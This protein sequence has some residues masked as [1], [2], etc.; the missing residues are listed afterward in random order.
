MG[1]VRGPARENPDC[2]NWLGDFAEDVLFDAFGAV[3]KM[4]K[5]FVGYD[6]ICR[7]G[8]K[9]DA[10]S[11]CYSEKYDRWKFDIRGNDI[12]DYIICIGF[13]NRRSLEPVRV[14][15]IPNAEFRCKT[16]ITIHSKSGYNKYMIDINNIRNVCKSK[17][18]SI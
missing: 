17:K 13:D 6:F 16:G 1:D 18:E 4:P 11:C 3:Q 10:K 15:I 2:A 14:W 12:A 5:N 8:Y 9:I 7:N